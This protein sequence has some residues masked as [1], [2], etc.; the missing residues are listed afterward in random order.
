MARLALSGP[1]DVRLLTGGLS[2]GEA[3]AAFNAAHPQA[4]G[5]ASFLGKV[6][7]GAGESPV[8]ALE[9]THY[10]PLTLCGME[11]L[12][13]QAQT[14][15]GLDGV[16]VWHRIGTLT[17]GEGIVLV[18]AAARHRRGALEAVDFLM[19]HLK[20]AA[21]LWKRERRG[22]GWHWIEPRAEDHAALARW[23]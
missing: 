23:Q 18:A 17:P 19:D 6:R 15:F 1:L 11:Q 14:R 21:W 2:V 5:V 3:L 16:L 20:S 7:P 9:L 12:A 4:G 8:K 13:Q 22:D 10:E